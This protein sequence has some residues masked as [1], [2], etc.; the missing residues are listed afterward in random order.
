MTVY[1]DDLLL[2]AGKNDEARLLKEIEHHVKLGEPATSISK[3]L[4]G[5]HKVVIEGGVSTLTTQMKNLL[6][7]AAENFRIESGAERLASVRTLY[8]PWRRL[9]REGS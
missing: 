9:R 2:A 6:L 3:F 4:G 8:V 7:D 5:H 1:V